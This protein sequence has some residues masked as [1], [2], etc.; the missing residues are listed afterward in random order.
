MHNAAFA[1]RMRDLGGDV[2]ANMFALTEKADII[3]FAGG[4]PSPDALPVERLRCLADEILC[5]SGKQVLQYATIDGYGPLREWLAAWMADTV[6]SNTQ[7]AGH[8]RRAQ[9]IDLAARFSEPRRLCGCGT[10]YTGCDP[11][12]KTYERFAAVESNEGIIP[13]PSEEVVRHNPKLL[14]VVPI[15]NPTGVTIPA[16]R[17]KLL[18]R[19]KARRA[20]SGG[21][22][23]CQAQV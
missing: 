16:D 22:S 17:R 21:R 15:Q 1:N 13:G 11:I 5:T 10:A 9:G 19:E 3:S 20:H 2:V 12:F 8:L 14:Y 6:L 4:I 7:R 18:R 23:I